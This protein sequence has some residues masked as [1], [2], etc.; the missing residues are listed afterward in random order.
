MARVGYVTNVDP[1]SRSVDRADERDRR[2][3]VVLG[4]V[5]P[6]VEHR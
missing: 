1:S 5:F 3:G 2:Q 6:D 4:G